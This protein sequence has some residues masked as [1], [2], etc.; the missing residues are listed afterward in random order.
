[1]PVIAAVGAIAVA[2]IVAGVRWL[3]KRRDRFGSGWSDF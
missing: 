1:M 3:K 2:G